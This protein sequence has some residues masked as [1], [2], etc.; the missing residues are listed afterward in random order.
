MRTVDPF[1]RLHAFLSHAC[2]LEGRQQL[3]AESKSD[4]NRFL[5]VWHVQR[6]LEVAKGIR[7][8]VQ[9]DADEPGLG[10]R[11]VPSRPGGTLRE[12]SK[13]A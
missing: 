4:G 13:D 9:L 6:A 10:V 8:L 5:D 12:T 2:L 11:D 7:T 1:P 3:P